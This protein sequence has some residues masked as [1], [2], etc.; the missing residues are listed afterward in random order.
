M[1]AAIGRKAIGCGLTEVVGALPTWRLA[2]KLAWTT[3]SVAGLIMFTRVSIVEVKIRLELVRAI[4]E[5][6]LYMKHK[7]TLHEAVTIGTG[8]VVKLNSLL[9]IRAL[10]LRI[11]TLIVCIFRWASRERLQQKNYNRFICSSVTE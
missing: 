10:G 9:Q 7:P 2:S 4:I 5:P 11:E 1:H 8:L 6:A 3:R